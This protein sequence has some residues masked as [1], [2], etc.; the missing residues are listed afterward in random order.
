VRL[1]PGLLR[2]ST[3]PRSIGS[4]PE[5]KMIGM[6]EVAA[7]AARLEVTSR[8]VRLLPRSTA[9]SIAVLASRCNQCSSNI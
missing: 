7:M 8:L 5:T 1:P 2:L 4:P 3:K 6:D 9:S